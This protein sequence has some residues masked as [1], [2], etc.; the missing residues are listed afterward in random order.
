MGEKK[1]N[2]NGKWKPGSYTS[3]YVPGYQLLRSWMATK[4]AE[5]NLSKEDD[6]Q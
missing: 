5:E 1:E 6:L 2:G 4:A 3:C